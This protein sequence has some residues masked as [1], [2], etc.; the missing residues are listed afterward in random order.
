MNSFFENKKILV[1]GAGG[2]IGSE[3]CKQL[4]KHNAKVTAVV[5][6][7]SKI[8]LL[9]TIQKHITIKDADLT[10]KKQVNALVKAHTLVIHAAA[11]DGGK[12]FKR[13][14]ASRIFHE[15]VRITMNVF[16]SLKNKQVEK[17]LFISSAE[18]YGHLQNKKHIKEEDFFLAA[19]S[20]E[21][22]WYGFSKMIGEYTAQLIGNALGIQVIV[23]RAANIY[24]PF[25]SNKKSRLVPTIIS[26]LKKEKGKI[27][28]SGTGKDIRSFLHVEDYVLNVLQLLEKSRGGI[29]NIAGSQKTTIESFANLFSGGKKNIIFK[30]KNTSKKHSTFILDI[31]KAKNIIPF[32]YDTPYKKRVAEILKHL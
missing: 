6:N 24:G 31:S 7:T 14:H 26:E 13:K 1:T 18:V 30:D 5:R 22:Q 9:S 19:P 10:D 23:V 4:I 11:V 32:W 17:V 12:D 3:F 28:L 16:E 2:F 21:E 27:I 25:D 20:Q 15:N 29:Y 8:D